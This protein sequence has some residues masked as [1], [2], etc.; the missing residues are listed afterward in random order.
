MTT[1][2]LNNLVHWI[3]YICGVWWNLYT[4]TQY[5]NQ[6]ILSPAWHPLP[7]KILGKLN[8]RIKFDRT[9]LFNIHRI[10]TCS[11]HLHVFLLLFDGVVT[12]WCFGLKTILSVEWTSIYHTHISRHMCL[13][14]TILFHFI[15]G[16]MPRGIAN[17]MRKSS[18]CWMRSNMIPLI[19]AKCDWLPSE[20]RHSK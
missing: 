4:H 2:W 18:V 14:D 16:G 6:R 15:L 1:L 20:F 5:A 10:H 12:V 7:S 3:V 13:L 19:S 17:E 11:L 9:H 8:S